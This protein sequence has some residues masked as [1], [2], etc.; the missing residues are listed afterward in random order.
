MSREVVL[1][2]GDD[3]RAAGCGAA[4]VGERRGVEPQRDRRRARRVAVRGRARSRSHAR[5]RR[6][7]GSTR[8]PSASERATSRPRRSRTSTASCAPPTGDRA[9]PA[10]SAAR[11][12][13]RSAGRPPPPAGAATG[14]ASDAGPRDASTPTPTPTSDDGEQDR[15]TAAATIERPSS[16][17]GHHRPST[18]PT[19]RTVSI[20]GGSPSLRRRYGDVAVDDVQASPRTGSPTRARAPASRVTTLRAFRSSSS[21]SVASRALNANLRVPRA[22]VRVAG[23]KEVPVRKHL[24]GLTAATQQRPHPREQLLRRERLDEIVVRA[25]IEALHAIGH[26]V[27]S[28][29][30]QDRQRKALRTNPPATASPSSP[31]IATSSTTRSGTER[32]RRRQRRSAVGAKRRRRSPRPR[33]SAPACA[34]SADRHPRPGSAHPSNEGRGL[35][36]RSYGPRL[37]EDLRSN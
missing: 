14:R 2:C 25:C 33:A 36:H 26:S 19:P 17:R 1:R 16:E 4:E 22:A 8:P 15:R 3:D 23:R 34:R 37:A 27:A 11:A 13:T 31:G 29:Q 6:P 28:R 10:T 20:S 21:S 5:E 9:R 30:Q 18:K 7:T 12:P 24:G 32:S 35:L